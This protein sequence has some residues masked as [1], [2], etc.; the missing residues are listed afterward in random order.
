MRWTMCQPQGLAPRSVELHW[1]L[2]SSVFLCTINLWR[3]ETKRQSKLPLV[4]SAV[5][6]VGMVDIVG[7]ACGMRWLFAAFFV[8]EL[9]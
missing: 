4:W 5:G 2:L 6:D 7:Q 1:F 3:R 9:Q 8:F